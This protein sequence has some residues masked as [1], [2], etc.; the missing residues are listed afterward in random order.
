MVNAEQLQSIAAYVEQHGASEE[1]V[2]T[3]RS[4]YEGCHFTYCLD[5]D[6]GNARAYL[7]RGDFNI[8]LVNSDNHCSVLTNDE[9]NASGVVIAE[10]L[11]DW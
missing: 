1:T 10:V 8:Y 3:L 7:E 9:T 4:L 6:I 11:E 2:L 5:D